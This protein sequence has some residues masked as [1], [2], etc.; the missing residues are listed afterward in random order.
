MLLFNMGI[1]NIS[2]VE[3]QVL[4]SPM[5]KF[6]YF[7]ATLNIFYS[8]SKYKSKTNKQS[9]TKWKPITFLLNFKNLDSLQFIFPVANLAGKGR[10]NSL[11]LT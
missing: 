11:S 8:Q 5:V 6:G 10:K 3:T 4:C 7:T 1:Y 2:D 9:G